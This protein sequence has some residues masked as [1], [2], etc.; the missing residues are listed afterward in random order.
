[1]DLGFR[2][3]PLDG[4]RCF[5]ASLGEGNASTT[6]YLVGNK[7]MDP[8]ENRYTREN[9]RG[10]LLKACWRLWMRLYSL[11]SSNLELLLKLMPVAVCSSTCVRTD[12]LLR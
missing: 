5:Q 7:G 10:G 2:V 6:W 9:V 4:K 12:A 1:M 8:C 11:R 3:R